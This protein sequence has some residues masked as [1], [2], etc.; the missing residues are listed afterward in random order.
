MLFCSRGVW[1]SFR[2]LVDNLPIPFL[3]LVTIVTFRE[4]GTLGW[5]IVVE[6]HHLVVEPF[7]YNHYS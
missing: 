1:T 5:V 7:Y 3:V 6:T 2:A 4:W